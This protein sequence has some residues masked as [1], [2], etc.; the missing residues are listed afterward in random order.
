MV[1]F[2]KEITEQMRFA[3]PAC[4]SQHSARH[5]DKWVPVGVFETKAWLIDGLVGWP[6]T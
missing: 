3:G 6:Y 2:S 1:L 5:P 4:N